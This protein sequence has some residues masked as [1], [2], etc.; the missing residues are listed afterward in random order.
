MAQSKRIT[1]KVILDHLQAFQ[2]QINGRMD[3][4]EGRMGGVEGRMGGLEGRMDRME[5]NLTAQISAID[6]RLDAIEIEELPKRVRKLEKA[7]FAK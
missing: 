7:V 3:R 1:L 2:I 6:K 4:F 5:R